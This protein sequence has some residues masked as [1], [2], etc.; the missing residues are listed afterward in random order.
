MPN[1]TSIME[2]VLAFH[3][4]Y[5]FN[6]FTA[7][8]VQ[9]AL[10]KD[11]IDFYD[12]AALLSPAALPFLEKM[13]E[14]AQ[15]CTRKQFGN[16]IALFTPIY[17]ANY[18]ENQCVYCGFNCKNKIHRAKL[19]MEEIK[20]EYQAIAATGLKEILILTGES[21]SMSGIEYIGEA[22]ELAKKYFSLIG[23]EIYPVEVDEYKYLHEKGAD[24][25]TVFQETYNTETYKKVHLAGQKSIF[26]YRINAQERAILGGMRGVGFGALLG[27]DDF[28]HDAFCVGVHATL[29]Q[30]KY[31]HAEIAVSVPRLRP[32]INGEETNPR[33]VH[34]KE[35]LQIMCAY[36]LLMPF[37]SITISTRERSDFR[38]NAVNICATKISAGVSVGIGGH[39]EK[40]KGDEQFEISDPRSV[41]EVV[42]AL[43]QYG[44]QPSFN[45]YIR[46]I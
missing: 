46:L 16:T 37:A 43:Q 23:L 27:L 34:E 45:D 8:D 22:V 20:K 15:L 17:I 36:R 26:P 1:E 6:T 4:K 12:Y 42:D 21:R 3:D 24:F 19:N 5:D 41:D 32:Y 2:Q 11:R 10:N 39:S 38:N 25:V 33:D 28:R 30:R 18:C 44:L 31:P 29:I 14:K 13:A 40:E 9:N 35:L 7:K